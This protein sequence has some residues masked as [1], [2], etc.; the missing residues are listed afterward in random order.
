MTTE[1]SKKRRTPLS[2]SRRKPATHREGRD[3]DVIG[4]DVQLLNVVSRRVVGSSEPV[5]SRDTLS[6]RPDP[7][8]QN[9]VGVLSKN[10]LYTV[11]MSI[12]FFGGGE[13]E[14]RNGG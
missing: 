2:L 4:Q 10:I 7:R 3:H 13:R 14:T 9:T 12:L 11:Y 1:A 5:Q 8:G 6:N